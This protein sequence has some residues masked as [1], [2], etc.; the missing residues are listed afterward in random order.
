MTDG[1][2]AQLGAG[3]LGVGDWH[4]T[5]GTTLVLKGVSL[6]PV[7]DESGVVYSHRAPPTGTG[8][9]ARVEHRRRCALEPR[10]GR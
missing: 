6:E 10:A 1:C 3:A 9:P 5:L 8:F 2:A 4:S 7:H